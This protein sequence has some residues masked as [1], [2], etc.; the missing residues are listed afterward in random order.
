MGPNNNNKKPEV[1]GDGKN[2]WSCGQETEDCPG[3]ALL[4]LSAA[5]LQQ[6]QRTDSGG[7]LEVF[8]FRKRRWKGP[9]EGC[10]HHSSQVGRVYQV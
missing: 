2:L 3:R 6:S 1:I 5:L 8:I 9:S 7:T 4:V 10:S